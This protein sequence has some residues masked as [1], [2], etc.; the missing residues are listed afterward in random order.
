MARGITLY[1]PQ[2]RGYAV[3]TGGVQLQSA[4]PMPGVD[5]GAAATPKGGDPLTG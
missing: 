2:Q 4:L 3:N 1:D 5:V